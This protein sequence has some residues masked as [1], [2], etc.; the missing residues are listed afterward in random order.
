MSYTFYIHGFD[1]LLHWIKLN[2]YNSKSVLPMYECCKLVLGVHIE[3][4]LEQL[5]VIKCANRTYGISRVVNIFQPLSRVLKNNTKLP[6]HSSSCRFATFL[7]LSNCIRIWSFAAYRNNGT[8]LRN[9][10]YDKKKK[11]KN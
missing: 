1:K 11:K 10:K 3:L 5:C 7:G 2:S 9:C 6:S 8:A 4:V